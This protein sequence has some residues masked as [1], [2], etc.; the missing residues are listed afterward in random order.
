MNAV[1]CSRSE[2]MI[3]GMT[4]ATK[5]VGLGWEENVV[6]EVPASQA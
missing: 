1:E 6:G 3:T 2:K 5:I 4:K